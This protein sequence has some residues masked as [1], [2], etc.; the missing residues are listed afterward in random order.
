MAYEVKNLLNNDDIEQLDQNGCMRV[1][2]YKRDLSILPWTAE[3]AYY[4][5]QMGC[6]KRQIL[7]Q[8]NQRPGVIVQN[9]MMQWMLGE[10]TVATDVKGVGDLAHKFLKGAVTNES[11]IKPRY[12]GK[13][14][15]MLEP[16]Y[17]HIL[18]LNVA[19]WGGA[20]T[21]DDGM[22]LAAEDTLR[23]TTQ[24]RSNISSAMFGNMGLWNTMIQGNGILAVECDCPKEELVE[25]NLQNDTLKVDGNFVVAWSSSLQFTTE[26]STKTLIGSAVSG[27]GLVNVFRGTGKL[28]MMPVMGT[29]AE[30]RAAAF[31]AHVTNN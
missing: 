4:A 7:C 8:L 15:F 5:S 18:L 31:T 28:W 21:L 17:K 29:S 23:I 22:F 20:V 25:I 11:P 9:G 14:L 3:M 26:R 24:R 10:I 12:T 30:D 1:I 27:E 13:G 16:T 19:D 6:H 2:Q